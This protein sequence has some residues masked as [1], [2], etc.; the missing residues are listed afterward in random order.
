M[1]PFWRRSRYG[2]SRPR[3]NLGGRAAHVHEAGDGP[4][5][6]DDTPGERRDGLG[7][8]APGRRPVGIAFHRELDQYL[9][10]AGRDGGGFWCSVPAGNPDR[11][12]TGIRDVPETGG[13]RKTGSPAAYPAKDL[14]FWPTARY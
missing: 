5:Q 6:E 12:E 1:Q 14:A 4:D 13:R 7:P 3:L 8:A 9:A 2:Q 11:A 10:P